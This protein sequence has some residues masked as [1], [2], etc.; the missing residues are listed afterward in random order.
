MSSVRLCT[1][2][3]P[4]GNRCRQFALR[5]QSR[6][7]AHSGHRNRLRNSAACRLVAAMPDMDLFEI[8][9]MLYDTVYQVRHKVIPPLHAYA[10]FEAA[11]DR[12][13]HLAEEAFPAHQ[14]QIPGANPN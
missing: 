14:Q 11:V 10:I 4:T 1:E 12:L 13:D 8:A 3:L 9:V 5:G 6:C 2:I 7:H